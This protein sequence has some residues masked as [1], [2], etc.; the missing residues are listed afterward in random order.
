MLAPTILNKKITNRFLNGLFYAL[1]GAELFILMINLNP[2]LNQYLASADLRNG[3]LLVNGQGVSMPELVN[4]GSYALFVF[5]IAW[6]FRVTYQSYELRTLSKEGDAYKV[7]N[8][9]DLENK[10]QCGVCDGIFYKDDIVKVPIWGGKDAGK[11]KFF[12]PRGHKIVDDILP[13]FKPQSVPDYVK[14]ADISDILI[15]TIQELDKPE[16]KEAPPVVEATPEVPVVPP[17]KERKKAKN[18]IKT[19]LSSKI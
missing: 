2:I 12:C 17:K 15:K 11:V 8:R 6:L 5:A 7:I 1:A 9:L 13:N 16:A 14:T 3:V 18:A 10:F 4:Y 19:I